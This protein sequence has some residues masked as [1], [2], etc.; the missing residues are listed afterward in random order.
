[1]LLMEQHLT[2]PLPIAEIARR[3]NLSTR[4]L[5]RLFQ[6]VAAMRPA[7][8]YRSLRLRYA[9]WLLDNTNRLVTDIALDAGFSDCAHFSRQFKAMHG[10]TPSETRGGQRHVPDPPQTQDAPASEAA[11]LAGFRVFG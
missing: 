3:L 8:F 10:F 9:R 5:E 1:M 6:T 2:D 11:R 4:Q 7:A